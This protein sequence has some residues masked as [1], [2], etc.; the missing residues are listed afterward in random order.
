M[1]YTI[2]MLHIYLKGRQTSEVY[3]HCNRTMNVTMLRNKWCWISALTL[4]ISLE[5]GIPKYLV[6]TE[7]YKN[8]TEHAWVIPFY[9]TCFSY[10][11]KSAR[12]PCGSLHLSPAHVHLQ[13]LDIWHGVALRA[14]TSSET[15]HSRSDVFQIIPRNCGSC[16]WQCAQVTPILSLCMWWSLWMFCS[17][18]FMKRF[19]RSFV[20]YL[21]GLWLNG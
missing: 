16:V 11:I 5:T 1:L 18:W 15:P 21:A 8:Y 4:L 20:G 12:S 17:S 2:S 6:A 9:L 13:W 10:S 7:L 3:N 19:F 14:T